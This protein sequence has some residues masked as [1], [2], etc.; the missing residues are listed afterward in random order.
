MAFLQC[1]LPVCEPKGCQSG[2]NISTT[3]AEIWLASIMN[4]HVLP[5]IA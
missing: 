1:A 2:N 4:Y 5:K 3:V